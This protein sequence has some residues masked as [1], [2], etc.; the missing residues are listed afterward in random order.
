[1]KLKPFNNGLY[2]EGIFAYQNFLISLYKDAGKL[3]A[4]PMQ[5]ENREDQ[6]FVK[7]LIAD[8][9]EELIEANMEYEGIL[10]LYI[11]KGAE[12]VPGIN[13]NAKT[14]KELTSRIEAYNIELADCLAFLVEIMIYSN[15]SYKEIDDWYESERHI[16]TAETLNTSILYASKI[17]SEQGLLNMRRGAFSVYLTSEISVSPNLELAGR[18][19]DPNIYGGLINLSYQCIEKIKL[20][21]TYLKNKYWRNSDTPVRSEDYQKALMNAWEAFMQYFHF[22]GLS[23]KTLYLYYEKKNLINQ[24]R[25]QGDY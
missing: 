17:N 15:I 25:I 6:V 19:I 20:A 1:M 4:P 18:F 14:V 24:E 10:Q 11:D 3:K 23:E 13:R 21:G 12:I 7:S 8:L 9:T 22:M 2:L 16:G 5:F